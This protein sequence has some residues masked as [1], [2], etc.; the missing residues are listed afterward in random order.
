M[1]TLLHRKLSTLLEE[2]GLGKLS[3][4]EVEPTV[5]LNA[6]G[7]CTLVYFSSLNGRMNEMEFVYKPE[8]TQYFCRD[9]L[10]KKLTELFLSEQDKRDKWG[11]RFVILCVAYV[12]FTHPMLLDNPLLFHIKHDESLIREAKEHIE[13][14]SKEEVATV[15][16]DN[17]SKYVIP[18][19]EEFFK[20]ADKP[21]DEVMHALSIMLTK[22]SAFVSE[23]TLD[24]VCWVLNTK[25]WTEQMKKCS[26]AC[27][28]WDEQKWKIVHDVEF[29]L[30]CYV[31]HAR[32]YTAAMEEYSGVP[33]VWYTFTLMRPME[34]TKKSTVV[35]DY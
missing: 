33:G 17:E 19:P 22:D 30:A 1:E 6:Y 10:N 35:G 21:F 25:S 3:R 4:I 23:R 20:A 9:G 8:T 18:S 26:K 7:I 31:V 28:K 2:N 27:V 34:S 13:T 29:K 15:M 32:G 14:V 12:L 24:K 5:Q 16:T 11:C